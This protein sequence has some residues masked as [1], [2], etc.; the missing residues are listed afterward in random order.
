METQTYE[1]ELRQL[2]ERL[3]LMA[4]R[5]EGMIGDAV[6]ALIEQDQ[7]LARATIL[8]DR[9]VN[10]DEMETD[11]LCYQ[12]L[13]RHQPRGADLRFVTLALKMVTDLERIGDLAVNIC[14]RALIL[15]H[16]LPVRSLETIPEMSRIVQVM[17]HDAI[18]AFVDRNDVRAHAVVDEDDAVDDLYRRF[19]RE[20]MGQ[21]VR[22]EVEIETG[23]HA[24]SVAKFLERM[25][26]HGTNIAEEVIFMVKGKDIRHPGK[27]GAETT[28]PKPPSRNGGPTVY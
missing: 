11:E 28:A 8:V 9:Q 4:G 15:T 27:G 24:Q 18:D 16:A 26:D 22:G 3:L 5:V 12:I 20:L 19:N 10:R 25:A 7:D 17:I 21:M 2:R 1:Q 6:R 13:A 14:E 23:F